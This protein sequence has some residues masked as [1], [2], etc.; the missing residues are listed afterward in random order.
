MSDLQIEN[1]DHHHADDGLQDLKKN[2]Q[3]SSGQAGQ[4]RTEEPKVS[5]LTP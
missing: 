4:A 3:I 1:M 5:T 2:N